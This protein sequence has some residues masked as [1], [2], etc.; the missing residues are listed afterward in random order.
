MFIVYKLTCT[1]TGKSYIG[2]SRHSLEVR[3][4]GHLKHA[5]A[6]SPTK[7]YRAIRKYGEKAF[8]KEILEEVVTKVEAQQREI[9]LIARY[10]TLKLGYNT[11]RGGDGGNTSTERTLKWNKHI[12]ESLKGKPKSS[13]HRKNM[14]GPRPSVSGENNPFYGKRHS[15]ETKEKIANRPY[16]RGDKHHF[17]QKQIATSFK[18]GFDHPRST[19]VTVNGIEYGSLSLAAKAHNM[20]RPKLKRWLKAGKVIQPVP[21]P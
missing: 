17:Y 20:T 11:T 2:Y 7:L 9:D 3:W 6:G 16:I 13:E 21:S 8:T 4:R 1:N 19:P 10:Q 14:C 15:S 12:S 18:P 5:K